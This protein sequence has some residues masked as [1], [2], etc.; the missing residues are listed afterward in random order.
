MP[1]PDAPPLSIKYNLL[2]RERCFTLLTPFAKLLPDSAVYSVDQQRVTHIII[3]PDTFAKTLCAS[4]A[5]DIPRSVTV[6]ERTNAATH[7]QPPPEPCLK[8]PSETTHSAWPRPLP[9][10]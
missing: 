8:V 9:L 4:A 3:S 6:T 10:G 7:T 1:P 2:K 5:R